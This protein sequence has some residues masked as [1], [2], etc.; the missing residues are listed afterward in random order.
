VKLILSQAQVILCTNTGA[1]E[2]LVQNEGPYDLVV[3]DEAGQ[4][5][6]PSCWIPLLQVRAGDI[7]TLPY[8]FYLDF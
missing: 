3:V 4:A 1:A 8:F 5:T 2:S 7:S 6:E